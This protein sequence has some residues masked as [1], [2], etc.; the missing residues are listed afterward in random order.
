MLGGW[1]GAFSFAVL[2]YFPYPKLKW[3]LPNP[4]DVT[5]ANPRVLSNEPMLYLYVGCSPLLYEFLHAAVFR[6]SVGNSYYVTP[7]VPDYYL[8][9]PFVGT[10]FRIW[11][12]Y[13]TSSLRDLLQTGQSVALMASSQWEMVNN[14][15]VDR[16]APLVCD[17]SYVSKLVKS[18]GG[19]DTMA[20]KIFVLRP[21]ERVTSYYRFFPRLQLWLAKDRKSVV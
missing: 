11:G 6:Q 10:A 16:S 12:V 4:R 3:L 13:G 21:I 5:I 18:H 19:S 1:V 15:V 20:H 9:V 7:V 2:V 14:Y 8:F 17:S